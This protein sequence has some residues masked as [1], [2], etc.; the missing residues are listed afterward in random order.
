MAKYTIVS[1][2]KSAKAAGKPLLRF[3]QRLV[4]FR[5]L[6]N[7]FAVDS[8]EQLASQLKD[9]RFEGC[10]ADNISHFYH[11]LTAG[12]LFESG[13]L[14][15][16][17]LLQYDQNI[18]RHTCAINGRRQ[19]TIRWKYFQYLA[20]LFSEIYLDRYFRNPQAFLNELNS[21]VRQFNSNK[22]PGDQVKEY[23]SADL[24]KLAFWNATGSGKTL[25]MH[26]NILQYRHYL[27]Q[28]GRERE[29]NHVILLTPNEGLSRQHLE[30][31][32]LSELPAE[33]FE[34]G[35]GS[36]FS[37][38]H[39]EII[40]INKL[41]EDMGQKTVAV[42]AFEGN[43]LL[44]VDEGHRGSSG[45]VWKSIRDR[46]C[47]SGFSFEYS[48]TFGQA[49][50]AS[51][52]V[53]LIQEYARCILFDYSY[54][55]FYKDGYGKD[56]RILNLS[57]DKTSDEHRPLY[58][59]AC[60]LAYYQQLKLYR[61]K[62][63][64][65]TPFLLE[66][67]LWMFVGKSVTAPSSTQLSQDAKQEVSD[68]VNILRFLDDFA[69]QGA[70]SIAYLERL[71]SGNTGLMDS[72]GRDLFTNA[73]SY[74]AHTGLR[75][76]DLY[77]DILQVLF[78]NSVPGAALHLDNFKGVQGEIG[79]RL[80]D[81]EYFGVINVGADK[82]LLKLCKQA[83][84]STDDRDFST[85]LFG[86]INER[87]S[88]IHILIGSKKFSEGWSSWRVSTMGLLNVGKK[89]GSEI[90]QLFGRGVRLKGYQMS[91]KRS[92][93]ICPNRAP[94]YIQLA[95]TL[96][97]F[98]VRAEYMKQFQ[99]YLAE[100]GLPPDKP[101]EI[102]LPVLR[103]W[104]PKHLLKVLRVRAGLNYRKDGS[105]PVLELPPDYLKRQ[106]VVLNWYP[107][108]QARIASGVSGT[109]QEAV[110]ATG[111]FSEKQLT[112][113]DWE[114]IYFE[115]LH[116]K[117]DKAR[118]NLSISRHVLRDIMNCPDWYTLF[119][120]PEEMEFTSFT[121]VR[122]WQE[123]VSILL[124]KYCD[125]FYAYQQKAWE[126]PNL[127]YVELA[128]DDP[129]LIVAYDLTLEAQETS[130]L[131]K[132]RQ[133]AT[134]MEEANRTG[135]LGE[136]N[137]QK[138][139]HH[140]FEPIGLSNHLF[141]PLLSLSKG[142]TS[143]EIKPVPLNDG[144]KQFIM[145]LKKYV[146]KQSAFFTDKDLF[147]LRNQSGGR[148]MKFFTGSQFFE[149]DFILWLF[150]EG[151][152]HIAFIDP[153]GISHSEGLHDPKI[154]FCRTIKEIETQL[155]DNSICLHSF[156]VSVTPYS[157]V[158]WWNGEGTTTREQ[159]EDLHVFFQTGD[160]RYVAKVLQAILE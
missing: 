107:R 3:D 49:M 57:E 48:A 78:H 106:K 131:E 84:L 41:K 53:D 81:S 95:E 39:I 137:F 98:G 138:F 143:L 103:H 24:S 30:E 100:E 29:L 13:G 31:F 134:V 10:D 139:G 12:Q 160:D 23:T 1:K 97:V 77:R 4:L 114:T 152:Q 112:F 25:L 148:G 7:L 44:L 46:L 149:P 99:E 28:Y 21:Y 125:R 42:D 109:V 108:I 64:E 74:I 54:K 76:D 27:V 67:P 144:E 153:K 35:Q 123:I 105:R 140:L 158:Q 115:L 69:R 110:L 2:T 127:E 142:Q 129:N 94:A 151:K 113:L 102:R 9:P 20:I 51:G 91:L 101:E 61:D 11:Q 133:L 119:I 90:I 117:H 96:N 79:L 8:L 116:Y 55:Y 72:R 126:M 146:A 17:V 70:N 121:Q 150:A 65:F 118:Y 37:G 130:L 82:E 147:L 47:A 5:Y 45:D 60:L 16:D 124:K 58:L 40:D 104:P 56:Y 6:L 14:T 68:V 59:T 75:T 157:I 34:K 135:T 145:D 66:K 156:I 71:L 15:A 38:G 120:A 73:Y 22:T 85:S 50:K 88:S 136:I 52:K 36:L 155:V 86:Q 122:K 33:I 80:G 18:F 63:P 83:G 89:E 93:E 26:V 128:A 141:E 111:I 32:R 62:E 43:N 159:F 87:V 132:L 154:Q 92:R 19:E